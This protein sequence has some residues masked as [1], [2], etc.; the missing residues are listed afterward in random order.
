MASKRTRADLHADFIVA[1]LKR[2]L[3]QMGGELGEGQEAVLR[4][5]AYELTHEILDNMLSDEAR[6][7]HSAAELQA[8]EASMGESS[9]PRDLMPNDITKLARE[10]EDMV[11][12]EP[13][14][15]IFSGE[16]TVK[17]QNCLTPSGGLASG[18]TAVWGP[19][20]AQ[21]QINV[22]GPCVRTQVETG[23]WTL[24]RR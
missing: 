9:I 8:L 17:G 10:R 12:V 22:C 5:F 7:R 11:R 4:L 15:V 19:L 20:P 6:K 23:K 2:R 13:S 18:V 21:G 16:C 3:G 14:G 1:R 24:G